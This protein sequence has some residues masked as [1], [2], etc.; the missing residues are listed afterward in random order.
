MPLKFINVAKLTRNLA[1]EKVFCSEFSTDN[2]TAIFFIFW[3]ASSCN[4]D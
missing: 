1:K 4:C 2:Y 3:A